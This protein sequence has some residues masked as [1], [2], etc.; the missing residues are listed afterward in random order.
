M[1]I[2]PQKSNAVVSQEKVMVLP[3]ELFSDMATR[4]QR[5]QGLHDLQVGHRDGVVGGSTDVLLDD[6]DALGKEV[7]V[8]ELG[9][10][11]GNDHHL[12]RV[13]VC[14]WCKLEDGWSYLGWMD[15]REKDGMGVLLQRLY[16]ISVTGVLGYIQKV[17]I[18]II[19][20]CS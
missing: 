14:S 19:L 12:G 13:L 11:L 5:L 7:L 6:Q 9:V 2:L 18:A 4:F 16:I 1:Q 20:H 15:G 10:G 3:V 8:D 17:T